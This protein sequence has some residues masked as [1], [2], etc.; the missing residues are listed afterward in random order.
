MGAGRKGGPVAQGTVAAAPQAVTRP[1]LGEALQALFNGV[2]REGWR[3]LFE[4]VLLSVLWFVFMLSTGLGLL[5]PAAFAKGSGLLI[6]GTMVL[7]PIALVGPATVGLFHA[8]DGI[9]SGDA[10]TIWDAFRGFFWGFRRRFRR[11]ASM[12]A[13]WALVALATYAN[14]VEDR[15]LIP[16]VMTY[17][18]DIILLYLLLFVVMVNVYLIG[19][20]ATTDF[21]LTDA[22]RLGAWQ[23]VANPVF[24]LVIIATA[25]VVV[26]LSFAIHA[27]FPVICGAAI[28]ML[29]TAALREAPLRHPALPSPL[30]PL[31]PDDSINPA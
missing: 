6:A 24:T 10:T 11:A 26:A 27:L 23:A 14:L 12:S 8:I 28:G 30:A 20:L 22:I 25:G 2:V 19:I 31:P 1:N 7:L 18:V 16:T 13:L 17:G 29:S 3:N 21:P 15:H 5:A 4:L 9:W